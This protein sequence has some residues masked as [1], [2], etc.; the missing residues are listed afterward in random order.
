MRNAHSFPRF[1]AL[2]L[3]LSLALPG[4]A[5]AL[6]SEQ[7]ADNTGL[8]ETIAQALGRSN[9]A[10]SQVA[11]GMEEVPQVFEGQIRA[12][13]PTYDPRGG[14]KLHLRVAPE[15]Y[16]AV[17]E[18]L[19]R[20]TTA[21]L[22][23]YKHLAGGE[24]DQKDFTVYVGDKKAADALAWKISADATIR[25]LIKEPTKDILETDLELAPGVWG[26]FE[27]RHAHQVRLGFGQ[28][29]GNGI[30]YLKKDHRT[31][32]RYRYAYGKRRTPEQI[33]Q[34]RMS[35]AALEPSFLGKAF[36]ALAKEFGIYFTGG[37]G[38]PGEL[39]SHRELE[40][41]PLNTGLEEPLVKGDH[42][43]LNRVAEWRKDKLNEFRMRVD[44][45]LPKVELVLIKGS[46]AY[47]SDGQN[48]LPV[49][50]LRS[51]VGDLDITV[52]PKS[53]G[54][55]D[56]NIELQRFY[57]DHEAELQDDL[58][59]KL[60]DSKVAF[61][62]EIDGVVTLEPLHDVLKGYAEYFL[63]SYGSDVAPYVGSN[64]IQDVW[65]SPEKWDPDSEYTPLDVAKRY[66]ELEQLAGDLAFYRHYRNRL[67]SASDPA[68]EA[69][70]ILQEALKIG[71][72]EALIQKLDDPEVQQQTLERIQERMEARLLGLEPT[73]S[74][75]AASWV[76]E[77]L[78]VQ[79]P[80]PERDR[81]SL[82]N[83]KE[84]LWW[85]RMADGL[86]SVL[87]R[88]T[89]INETLPKSH[90]IQKDR[91]I[92]VEQGF[93]S[94]DV[95]DE[96][97]KFSD[98]PVQE[99]GPDQVQAVVQEQKQEN[100][101]AEDHKSLFVVKEGSELERRLNKV[102]ELE[103][104]GWELPIAVVAIPVGFVPQPGVVSSLSGRE[105]VLYL[106]DILA[107]ADHIPQR[108]MERL[109]SIRKTGEEL[110]LLSTRA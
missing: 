25:N 71:R 13:P 15:N 57:E 65:V 62:G 6:R 54:L 3:V 11:A 64:I 94:E 91:T 60:A 9:P 74:E 84:T 68:A 95:R 104:A 2:F 28:Y 58:R 23:G 24:P 39:V 51:L 41:S 31:T 108:R 79:E 78:G 14:W 77:V 81:D 34:D 18:W 103:D 88:L 38:S 73:T 67:V 106:L 90:N 99:I 4:P 42:V 17:H 44:P 70:E 21:E 32:I 30:P 72:R 29:G 26:R 5:L 19:W 7:P 105:L 85:R 40:R 92:Y 45:T 1:L 110:Q 16:Q 89:R 86:M 83:G 20:N 22:V 10:V 82:M 109:E 96:L 46:A 87:I 27:V 66:L 8:E 48:R 98:S 75:Q 12:Y 76:G 101:K 93:L 102:L 63:E 56:D 61:S 59:K 53:P 80:M 36:N 97:A 107:Q 33:Q 69:A 47:L 50:A 49:A 37:S 52:L 100:K 55:S 43:N 35:L